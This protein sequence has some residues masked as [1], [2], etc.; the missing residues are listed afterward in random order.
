MVRKLQNG[1]ISLKITIT[2]LRLDTSRIQVAIMFQL[3][4]K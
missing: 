2:S 1:L 3:L 4:L